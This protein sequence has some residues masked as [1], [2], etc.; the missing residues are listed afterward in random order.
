MP[1]ADTLVS[2]LN[3]LASEPGI[4]ST[5]CRNRSATRRRRELGHPAPA[6]LPER[7]GA[8]R[9][10][11]Q[12][13]P[14]ASRERFGIARR[15]PAARSRR[16]APLRDGR[17]SARHHRPA[18]PPW[19]RE[20]R[21]RSPPAPTAGRRRRRRRTPPASCSR[22]TSPRRIH[23]LAEA[24]LAV[25][26][27]QARSIPAPARRCGSAASGIRSRSSAA[28]RRRSPSRLRGYMRAT[29]EHDGTP[30][31]ADAA[32]RANS[33]SHASRSMGSGTT[34]R[35]SAGTPYVPPA[36]PPRN[37]GSSP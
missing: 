33:A 24:Q 14:S 28:A 31:E 13:S 17:R 12:D 21:C 29:D 3:G 16:R 36:P 2:P 10:L 20:T 8:R 7:V 15:P 35:R 1:L 18:R 27:D 19:L 6:R 9:I 26:A 11:E 25:Q 4:D 5:A 22:V 37:S 34:A 32:P 30:R 23:R